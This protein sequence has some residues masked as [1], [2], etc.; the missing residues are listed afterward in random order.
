MI[1]TNDTTA[2]KCKHSIKYKYITILNFDGVQSPWV[3]D[4]WMDKLIRDEAP[5]QQ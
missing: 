4:G 2:T 3:I 5:T 1:K